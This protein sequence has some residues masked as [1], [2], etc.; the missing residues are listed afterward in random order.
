M[1]PRITV[2]AVNGIQHKQDAGDHIK[3]KIISGSSSNAIE[4]ES[5]VT[6]VVRR[7]QRYSRVR[8]KSQIIRYR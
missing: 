2:V 4:S 7:R 5:R 6:G 8:M 3:F 1:V